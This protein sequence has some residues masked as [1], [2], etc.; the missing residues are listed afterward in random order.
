M[1]APA[2]LIQAENEGTAKHPIGQAL[3]SFGRVPERSE[4]GWVHL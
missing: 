4:G 2:L 1:F 3:P